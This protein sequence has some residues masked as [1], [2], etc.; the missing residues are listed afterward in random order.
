MELKKTKKNN[1]D[2]RVYVE[3][4]PGDPD[5]MKIMRCVDFDD[6]GYHIYYEYWRERKSVTK[7]D[8][9][10]NEYILKNKFS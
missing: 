8:T 9:T 10:W 2:R 3:C 6:G 5:G 4:H 7:E 1:L